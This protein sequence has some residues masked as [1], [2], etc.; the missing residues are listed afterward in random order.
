M[1]IAPESQRRPGKFI[2]IVL[3]VIVVIGVIVWALFVRSTPVETPQTM[4][5][6]SPAPLFSPSPSPL[7]T[8]SAEQL[9]AATRVAWPNGAAL[10]D[11]DG[12][13]YRF[14]D[15]KLVL[16]PFGPVLVSE[17][18]AVDPAHVATGR[19]DITYL[20]PAGEGFTVARRFPKA[21]EAGSFGEMEGWSV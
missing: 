5:G 1:T 9:A 6:A 8:A 13:R 3:G 17:G 12:T 19:L 14:G 4:A 20:A 15:G 16:A 18:K 7:A 10:T 11:E 2:A 21:V